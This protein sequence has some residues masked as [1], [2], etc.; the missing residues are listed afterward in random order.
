[1]SHEE[2]RQLREG[3]GA[4][5][6]G[7][8]AENEAAGL[9]AHLDGCASCR[10]E[11]A[12]IAPLVEDLRGVDPAALSSVPTPPSGLGDQIRGQIAAERELVEA[13]ERRAERGRAVRTSTRRA[14][15]AAAVVALLAGAL[16]AGTVLGRSTAPQVQALPAPASSAPVVEQVALTTVAGL[17]ADTA[18]L[19]AHTW[20]VEARF[21]GSGFMAGRVY[22]AAFRAQDGRMVP[23]GEFL[24]TGEKTLK[25]NMQSALLRADAAGFVVVD[26]AGAEVLTAML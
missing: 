4:L 3:L 26:D 21:E 24:G 22:R 15:A 25:C 6:L 2:H 10:A 17:R 13:R 16:G 1:M 9:R 7:D 20:G 11:L 5:A 18:G 14:V 19:I 8:L 12:E 23:A